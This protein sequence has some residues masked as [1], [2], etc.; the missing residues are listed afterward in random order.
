MDIFVE[1]EFDNLICIVFYIFDV[2][3]VLIIL[4]DD[5]WQWFKF[6]VGFEV[7]G[8]FWEIFFCQYVIVDGE[9]FIVNDVYEDECFEDNLFVIGVFYIWFYVGYFIMN[10]QG[11]SLGMI[12]VIDDKFCFVIL[13]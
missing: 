8:M 5:K 11:Y 6:K 3:I 7:E 9:M 4:L 13:E 1:Q 12:C 10:E 2:F